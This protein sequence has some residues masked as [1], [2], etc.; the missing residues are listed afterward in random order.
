MT[1]PETVEPW[2]LLLPLSNSAITDE[3]DEIGMSTMMVE[4]FLR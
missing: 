2:G 3:N 4:L 1:A